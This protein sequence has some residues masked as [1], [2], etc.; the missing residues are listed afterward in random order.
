MKSMIQTNSHCN[1]ERRHINLLRHA[2]H[3]RGD[4]GQALIELA[5]TFPIFILL[6][7]GGAEMARLAYAVI[8]VSNAA[9]AGAAYGAQS[10]TT[11]ADTAAIESAATQDGSNVIGLAATATQ[12]CSC[13]NAP[14]TQVSCATAPTT[15]SPAPLHSLQYVQ[16]NTTA[17]ISAL[18]NYPGLSK[19]YTLHGQAIMR[20]E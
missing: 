16:V 6:L 17:T 12:F 1:C 5:L 7:V 20:V 19:S 18:F 10:A 13:S 11:A 3:S 8:E 4:I 15:C 2:S 14:S 9:R